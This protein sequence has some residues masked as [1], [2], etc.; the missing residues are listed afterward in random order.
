[1]RKLPL[2]KLVVCTIV[3]LSMVCL[4]EAGQRASAQPPP[5]PISVCQT[6][7]SCGNYNCNG[8]TYQGC[9][10]TAGGTTAAR[11][12][13]PITEKIDCHMPAGLPTFTCKGFNGPKACQNDF[14]TCN[15]PCP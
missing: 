9:T 10:Y 2:R 14:A 8:V 12:P 4:I 6:P 7:A 15:G 5:P 11:T 3:M 13:R 1:M